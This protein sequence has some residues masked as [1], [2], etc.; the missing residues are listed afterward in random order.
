[1]GD[2]SANPRQRGIDVGEWLRTT[3][4]DVAAAA[5]SPPEKA[6]W[7]KRL[8]AI[9]NTSKHDL[10]RAEEQAKRFVEEWNALRRGTENTKDD[11][12]R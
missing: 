9:T 2:H 6:R 3:F 7:Q 12:G 5:I 10:R 1:M 8:I 11:S 4:A